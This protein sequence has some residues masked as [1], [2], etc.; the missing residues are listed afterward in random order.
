ME[1]Y[2]VSFKSAVVNTYIVREGGYRTLTDKLDI[3]D[4]CTVKNGL[5]IMS[6]WVNMDFGVK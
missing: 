5:R 4:N 1:K 2:F 3:V 6:F